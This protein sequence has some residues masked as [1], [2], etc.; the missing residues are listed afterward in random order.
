[1]K[2]KGTGLNSIPNR[3]GLMAFVLNTVLALVLC[4]WIEVPLNFISGSVVAGLIAMPVLANYLAARK[5]AGMIGSLRDSTQALVAG[6][7]DQPVDVDCNCEVGGLADGFRAMVNRLNSNILR[8]NVLAYTDAVTGLPNR[9]VIT[10]I[11]SLAK[12]ISPGECAATMMFIDLD[13]FKRVNDTLGHDAGD[14]LLR[15]AA[16]R[17]I[18]QGLGL[19]LADLDQCTTTFGELCQ[20]CPTRPVFARFAGDE[21]VLILPGTPTR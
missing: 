12:Q 15:Q 3:F 14:E 19:T 8:M 10:H 20:T 18:A 5:L 21:F 2:R 11:L 16:H 17:I 9:S 13:G 6:N 4:S 7:F 1:M